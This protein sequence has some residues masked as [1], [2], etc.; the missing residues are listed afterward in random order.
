MGVILKLAVI[1]VVWKNTPLPGGLCPENGNDLH[2][3]LGVGAAAQV[4]LPLAVA[5]GKQQ[6]FPEFWMQNEASG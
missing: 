3:H 1:F 6:R 2:S 4:R 5:G